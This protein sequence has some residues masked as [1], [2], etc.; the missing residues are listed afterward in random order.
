MINW[1]VVD[2]PVL[3]ACYQPLNVPGNSGYTVSKC[4]QE[5]RIYCV[6]VRHLLHL[7]NENSLTQKCRLSVN[8]YALSLASNIVSNV[9]LNK[10]IMEINRNNIS[11]L[12]VLEV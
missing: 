4:F 9:F 7:M 11:F 8:P 12:F 6:Q 10:N 1:T 5:A 3:D 2:Q